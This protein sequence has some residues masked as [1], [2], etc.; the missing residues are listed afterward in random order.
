MFVPSEGQ[1]G[2]NRPHIKVKIM[3]REVV[4]LLDSGANVSVIK[5]STLGENGRQQIKPTQVVIQT[6]N[7]DWLP[8]KGWTEIFIGCMQQEE[9]LRMLV[10]GQGP[11]DL[12]LGMD[13]WVKF[14]LFISMVPR[15]P[16]KTV[17]AILGNV[18]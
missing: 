15:E 8:V 11:M 5:E 6:A 3:G 7:G 17:G 12:I 16:L 10:V 2:D 18:V 13:F 14:G 9:E 1:I 4:G